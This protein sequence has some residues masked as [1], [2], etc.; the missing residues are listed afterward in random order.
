MRLRLKASFDIS[1]FS[2]ANQAILTAMKNYGMIV[3]DNGSNM[4]FQGAPDARWDDNDLDALKAIDAS[5]FD[6]VQMGTEY[7]AS[8]APTGAAPTISSFTASQTT[9]T[10]GT[11]VILSWTV[12]N[13]SYDYIDAVGPVRAG[14]QTVTPA[15]TTIYTLYSTNQF[16]RA[17]KSV[18]VNVQ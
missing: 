5:N 15:A 14:T 12:S 17:T 13:D 10:A 9:V 6:V 4:Y 1:G 8:T 11:P 2:A 16:G 7:D 18:T 3:A